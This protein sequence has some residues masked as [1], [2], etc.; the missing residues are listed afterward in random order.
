[1]TI[2]NRTLWA[3]SGAA[4]LSLSSLAIAETS[5]ARYRYTHLTLVT[6][7]GLLVA[8]VILAATVASLWPHVRDAWLSA[9]GL[10]IRPRWD[11]GDTPPDR[12][13]S[14][15]R[16]VEPEGPAVVPIETGPAPGEPA[17][18]HPSVMQAAEEI[19]RELRRE[20]G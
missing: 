3:W 13:A 8:I 19:A 14:S 2:L 7:V 16:H 6:L 17:S 18:V 4:V 12:P 9:H 1:M 20:D 11:S 10:D 5:G 15:C